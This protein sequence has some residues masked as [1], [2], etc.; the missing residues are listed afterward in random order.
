[1]D[2][3]TESYIIKYFSHLLNAEENLALKHLMTLQKISGSTNPN[4]ERACRKAG[5]IT[6]SQSALDLL[7]DGIYNFTL[8]IATRIL[9]NHRSEI[10]L[11]NCPECGKL[12]RTPYARQCRHCAYKW[13]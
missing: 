12:A 11:N 7:K 9:E 5:W 8:K 3:D 1:M 6:D 4:L 13:Y 2:K 10:V